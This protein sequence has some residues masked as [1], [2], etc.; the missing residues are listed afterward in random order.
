MVALGDN[1]HDGDGAA[2]LSR[3]DRDS[4]DA[5]QRGCDWIWI[6][7]NHDPEPAPNI[8]GDFLDTLALGAL[9]FRHEPTGG[10]R[11]DRRPS[12]SDGAR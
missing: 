4:L 12:A 5:L 11:R 2:R 8:G 9:T 10:R 7:G 1:F 6:T 3:E